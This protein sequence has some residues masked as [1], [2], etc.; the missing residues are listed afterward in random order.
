MVGEGMV[1]GAIVEE[2]P[3]EEG[4]IEEG[5]VEEAH[6]RERDDRG[7]RERMVVKV[8]NGSIPARRC[9][10]QSSEL[11][12]V[13]EK[14]RGLSAQSSICIVSGSRRVC[15]GRLTNVF[16]GLSSSKS[17]KARV[18]VGATSPLAKEITQENT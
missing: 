12:C 1:G 2:G 16:D 13:L 18:V 3:V 11:L 9:L 14:A 4:V 8:E 6:I 7:K 15:F 17:T 10:E 5:L